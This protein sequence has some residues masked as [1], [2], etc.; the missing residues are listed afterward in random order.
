MKNDQRNGR[1]AYDGD[2]NYIS[3]VVTKRELDHF[4]AV[5]QIHNLSISDFA[6]L[7]LRLA[8]RPGAKNQI[9]DELDW[10][11]KLERDAKKGGFLVDR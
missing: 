11:K 5:A 8:S 1:L 10:R 4:T 2:I 6:M 3:V 7:A 9:L